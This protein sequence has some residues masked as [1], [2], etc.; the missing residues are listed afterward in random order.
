M[1]IVKILSSFL[2]AILK[3]S[4]YGRSMNDSHVLLHLIRRQINRHIISLTGSNENGI[5]I[6]CRFSSSGV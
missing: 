4:K 1:F 5:I 6:S 3:A 2:F